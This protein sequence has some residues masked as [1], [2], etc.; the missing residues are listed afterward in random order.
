M[1]STRSRT[2]SLHHSQR[3]N[4]QHS[5][6]H[7]N[8]IPRIRKHNTKRLIRP[9]RRSQNRLS[10]SPNPSPNYS[11]LTHSRPPTITN[12]LPQLQSSN[13]NR[14]LPITLTLQSHQLPQ[15]T[16]NRRFHILTQLRRRRSTRTKVKP[17]PTQN[18]RQQ[19][20][21]LPTKHQS[22][23]NTTSQRRN[24]LPSR[25]QQ[26]SPHLI[27]TN[28]KLRTKYSPKLRRRHLSKRPRTKH[29]S[30]PIHQTL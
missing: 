7:S 18:P 22:P 16:T 5:K 10:R 27:N 3:H 4:I 26:H 28:T 13:R 12:Q 29:L 30:Q 14:Q 19:H 15:P 11:N 8:R 23:T 17:Q 24:P 20:R 25:H 2:I 6:L 21:R 1:Q 9:R